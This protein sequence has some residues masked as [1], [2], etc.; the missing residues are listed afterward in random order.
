MLTGGAFVLAPQTALR[1]MMASRHY[2]NL[3][4]QFAGVMIIGL[5]IMAM[6]VI[7]YGSQPLYRATLVARI[8][9]WLIILAM[10][11]QTRERALLIVLA[12]LGLGVAITGSCYA[13]ERNTIS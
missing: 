6:S 7:R 9:M 3:F 5:S 2:D 10:Y 4:V 12:V 1:L 11:F 8:P 13:S